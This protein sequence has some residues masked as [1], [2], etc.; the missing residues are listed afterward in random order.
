MIN[1]LKV[2]DVD[3]IETDA[4]FEIQSAAIFQQVESANTD[5]SAVCNGN[6]YFFFFG[7]DVYEV[8][9]DKF[10]TVIEFE[11]REIITLEFRNLGNFVF[12]GIWE[13]L[14]SI[15]FTSKFILP[16]GRG[17]GSID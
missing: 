10:F 3:L 8:E 13:T 12:P 15:G 14:F 1:L 11:F 7:V 6:R 9:S 2:V 16:F 17:R 4:V 5:V